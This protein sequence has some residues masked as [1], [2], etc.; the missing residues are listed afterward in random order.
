MKEK[1]SVELQNWINIS[2]GFTLPEGLDEIMSNLKALEATLLDVEKLPD[3]WRITNDKLFKDKKEVFI[4]CA[5]WLDSTLHPPLSPS[6]FYGPPIKE[7]RKQ[8]HI[9]PHKG[10][11]FEKRGSGAESNE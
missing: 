3:E 6:I 2:D 4:Y 5:N 11:L 8:T 1:V 7:L 10:W 9:K